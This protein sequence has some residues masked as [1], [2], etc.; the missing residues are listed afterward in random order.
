MEKELHYIIFKEEGWWVAQCLEYDIADQARTIED[1][2]KAFK[3]DVNGII[4]FSKKYKIAPFDI[5]KPPKRY[6]DILENKNEEEV[7]TM[8]I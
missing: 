6:Q 3:R 8:T 1:A 4:A 7:Y 2:H 5:P